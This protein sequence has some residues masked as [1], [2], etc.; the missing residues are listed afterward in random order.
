MGDD[1]RSFSFEWRRAEHAE[2]TGLLVRE[3]FRSGVWRIL[4]GV[5]AM[6]LVLAVVVVVASL[7]LGD[8]GSALRL[9]APSPPWSADF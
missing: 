8:L 2:V 4:L 3:R 1:S 9:G 5:I 7:V 6:I